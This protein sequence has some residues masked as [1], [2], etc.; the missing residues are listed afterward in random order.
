MVWDVKTISKDVTDK[1]ELRW[2]IW[3]HKYHLSAAHHMAVMK[4][5]GVDVKGWGWIFVKS[6]GYPHIVVSPCDK[7]TLEFGK[8]DFEDAV[9]KI[10]ICLEKNEWPGM[11]SGMIELGLPDYVKDNKYR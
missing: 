4:A 8:R 7:E 5:C 10:K 1:D 3:N 6:S 2:A 9:G 11:P